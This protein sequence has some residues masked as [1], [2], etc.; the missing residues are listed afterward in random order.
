MTP[1]SR[2]VDGVGLQGVTFAGLAFFACDR[3]SD[4]ELELQG[5]NMSKLMIAMFVSAGLG[6]AGTAA[7]QL[8]APKVQFG[9]S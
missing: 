2:I 9:K 5:N 7:A 1:T 3:A 6:F 8:Y 4:T